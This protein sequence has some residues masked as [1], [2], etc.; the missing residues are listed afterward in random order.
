MSENSSIESDTSN[1]V[2][3]GLNPKFAARKE[4]FKLH[5]P[6]VEIPDK[7]SITFMNTL[8]YKNGIVSR[9]K[10][11]Y[12]ILKEVPTAQIFPH[13]VRDINVH[14][15]S[16]FVL[17]FVD[18]YENRL[19]LGLR[20]SCIFSLYYKILDTFMV[21]KQLYSLWNSKDMWIRV[22]EE[23]FKGCDITFPSSR[24]ATTIREITLKLMR[25]PHPVEAILDTVFYAAHI[26]CG[27]VIRWIN[28]YVVAKGIDK[29]AIAIESKDS[30]MSVKKLAVT[31]TVCKCKTH[32]RDEFIKNLYY[33]V[34]Y[35]TKAEN[36]YYRY[37]SE[38]LDNIPNM[39][40]YDENISYRNSIRETLDEDSEEFLLKTPTEASTR[41]FRQEASNY[42]IAQTLEF[43]GLDFFIYRI[44]YDKYVPYLYLNKLMELMIDLYIRFPEYVIESPRDKTNVS[45]IHI[46]DDINMYL[47]KNIRTVESL[48]TYLRYCKVFNIDVGKWSLDYVVEPM[49]RDESL[50]LKPGSSKMID[51]LVERDLFPDM[52]EIER[53][54]DND[55]ICRMLLST[56]YISNIMLYLLK[57]NPNLLMQSTFI[58][59][60]RGDIYTFKLFL[61]ELVGVSYPLSI[62]N[63]LIHPNCFADI[64]CLD[65]ML[66]LFK[67][68]ELNI[69]SRS[70]PET[71][72]LDETRTLPETSTLVET[73]TLPEISTLVETRTLSERSISQTNEV[74]RESEAEEKNNESKEG[75]SDDDEGNLDDS[76]SS[77]EDEDDESSEEDDDEE[78]DDD[79]SSDE[80]NDLNIIAGAVKQYMVTRASED[81]PVPGPPS[82]ERRSSFGSFSFTIKLPT[83]PIFAKRLVETR[84][85]RFN[86]STEDY[87]PEFIPIIREYLEQ[88]ISSIPCHRT[89]TSFY[90][91][92]ND[93]L[94]GG[95]HFAMKHDD[96]YILQYIFDRVKVSD[97]LIK[98][99]IYRCIRRLSKNS[100][101]FLLEKT[102]KISSMS[103]T[104]IVRY[105]IDAATLFESQKKNQS[106]KNNRK[107]PS[108]Y[109]NVI[110]TVDDY[111][112]VLELI[113]S[114][115]ILTKSDIYYMVYK[116]VSPLVK[117]AIVRYGLVNDMIAADD[118]I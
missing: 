16:F 66:M 88:I 25:I 36:V 49:R 9:A 23:H 109:T 64:E 101:L 33:R 95:M 82:P 3:E 76:E 51:A 104:R 37:C 29:E 110:R 6:H 26:G 90:K 67:N 42:I 24:D 27:D 2:V 116:K 102:G 15:M 69:S 87:G 93:N 106:I 117:D 61:R 57:P 113:Y 98:D 92:S 7:G 79:E 41:G 20:A 44:H 63:S 18:D 8:L 30:I 31:N 75:N 108:W 45:I 78:D 50:F 40:D 32:G 48:D 53:I 83:E 34:A 107:R 1:L 43:I 52:A 71:S 73:R 84:L 47:K 58:L 22:L 10:Y 38:L 35:S 112:D 80:D 96:V 65:L 103:A 54:K 60:V 115:R 81:R 11:P 59:C 99:Y 70:L 97:T 13:Y 74:L 17:S 39:P 85:F 89:V 12:D 114:H 111:T 5:F 105:L 19:R 72:T 55:D 21:C 77:E 28:K 46:A 91:S 86:I 62:H 118:M 94:I 100:L 68:Y 4:F 56:C 14:I